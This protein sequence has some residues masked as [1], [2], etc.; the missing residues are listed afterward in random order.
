MTDKDFMLARIDLKMLTEKLFN[1]RSLS[2]LAN[3]STE[4]IEIV[5]KALASI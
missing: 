4:D 5:Y 3:S 1:G 2:H